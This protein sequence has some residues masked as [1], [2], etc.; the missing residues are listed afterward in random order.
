MRDL[1]DNHPQI[2]AARKASAS[3]KEGIRGAQSGYYPKVSLGAD[4]GPE[5]VDSPGRRK[6][7]KEAYYTG[8]D[9]AGLTVTQKLFDGFATQAAVE[10]AKQN[11]AA[12]GLNIDQVRQNVMV[13]ATTAYLKVLRENNL[14][15]MAR[16]NE[17]NIQTQLNLEDERVKRGS[18]IAVDVLQAKSRLQIAKERRVTFEGDLS[19]AQAEYRQAFNR[20][21]EFGAMKDPEPP[22]ELLPK[23]LD[24]AI[25]VALKENPAVATGDAKLLSAREKRRAARA[26]YFP[27]LA[28]EGKANYEENKNTVQNIR[29]DWTLLLKANWDLF[30]GFSTQAAVAQAAYEYSGAKDDLD[31]AKRKVIKDTQVAW[32]SLMVARERVELLENAVNIATEVWESRKKLREAGKETVINVLDAENEIYN[33][34]IKYITASY[35]ARIAIY[36]LLSAMGRLDLEAVDRRQ[37]MN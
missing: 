17:G 5:Y 25:D 16:N 35:D 26:G 1:I 3:A 23:T 15:E 18:G 34:R 36:Q 24:E 37:A 8:R 32:K 19:K 22:V 27:T 14:I 2:Q 4:V 12:A 13:E 33:A 11:S 20:E 31:L 29:R 10:G 6:D 9:T 7:N 30:S 21:P 28:L